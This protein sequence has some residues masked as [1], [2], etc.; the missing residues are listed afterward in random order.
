MLDIHGMIYRTWNSLVSRGQPITV[1]LVEAIIKETA[2]IMA[3][4]IGSHIHKQ[5]PTHFVVCFDPWGKNWQYATILSSSAVLVLMADF[6]SPAF[7]FH[8]LELT[9]P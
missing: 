4:S 9:L 1:S 8:S 2:L 3:A 5:N 7:D 6:A